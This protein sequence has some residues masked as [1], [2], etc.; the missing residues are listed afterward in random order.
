MTSQVGNIKL[1]AMLEEKGL[2]AHHDKTCF[3]VCGNRKYKEMVAENLKRN[4]L[5]FGDFLLKD[6]ESD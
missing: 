2:E 3:I 6:R 4:P 5:M 1:F